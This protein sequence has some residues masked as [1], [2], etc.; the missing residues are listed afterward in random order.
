MKLR[1]VGIVLAFAAATPCGAQR[2]NLDLAFARLAAPLPAPTA[3]LARSDALPAAWSPAS[4]HGH[5]PALGAVGGALVGGAMS[6]LA[7]QLV[8]NDWGS[9]ADADFS[10]RRMAVTAGGSALGAL[11]GA[12]LAHRTPRAR[13]HGAGAAGPGSQ[14]IAPAEIR[15]SRA[16]NVYDLVEA[17]RPQWLRAQLVTSHPALDP[18]PTSHGGGAPGSPPGSSPSPQSP[19]PTT[20]F[21]SPAARAEQMGNPD[22]RR[23]VRVYMERSLLGDVNTLRDIPT[24]A[25]TS[26]EF[27][28]TAAAAYRLGPGSPSGAIV[29]HITRAP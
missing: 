16:V 11:G 8:W 14:L 25:V 28:D 5:S 22:A 29:L 18:N 7:S 15:A 6:Y 24:N 21:E 2:A 12:L 27:L 4:S 10:G 1:L 13:T 23:G 26:I 17:V 9:S 20:E 19:Q 3:R